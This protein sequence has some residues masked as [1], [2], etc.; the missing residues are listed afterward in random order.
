MQLVHHILSLAFLALATTASYGQPKQY[1][2]VII[3]GGTAGLAVANRLSELPHITVAVIEA[4]QDQSNNPIVTA[5]ASFSSLAFFGTAI[6]WAYVSTNQTYA[7]NQQQVFHAGKAFGGTSTING[8]VFRS[9]SLHVLYK[10]ARMYYGRVQ[11]AVEPFDV[12]IHSLIS[13]VQGL[14]V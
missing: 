3:G 10:G 7:A 12:N 11:G 1:D 8:T 6:D 9:F 13:I 5:A 2:Y 14:M 4:G